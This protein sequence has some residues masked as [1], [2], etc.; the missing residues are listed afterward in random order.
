VLSEPL[1]NMLQGV[2]LIPA[3]VVRKGE[4]LATAM[5]QAE[6]PG[7]RNARRTVQVHDLYEAGQS[8]ILLLRLCRPFIQQSGQPVIRIL[9][10]NDQLKIA[11]RL[12]CEALQQH[13]EF[14]GAADG[15]YNQ[16]ESWHGAS[17]SYPHFAD[18]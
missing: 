18:Q 8:I 12:I 4:N 13:G 10:D 6:V 9:I 2:G 7:P 1:I 17:L 14:I 15:C 16:A 11:K 3:I 5:Q